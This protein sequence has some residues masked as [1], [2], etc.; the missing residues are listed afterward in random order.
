V[1]VA[2]V[3]GI[4]LEESLLQLAPAGATMLAAVVIAGRA[5][6]GELRR[7]LRRLP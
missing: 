6:L 5:G 4:P 3:N 7:R 1:I 2:H